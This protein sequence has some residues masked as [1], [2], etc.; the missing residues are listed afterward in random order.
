MEVFVV[1]EIIFELEI[2]VLIGLLV[3]G[4]KYWRLFNLGLNLGSNS[5]FDCGIQFNICSLSILP[6][7]L[8]FGVNTLKNLFLL[9]VKLIS[10]LERVN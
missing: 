6:V 5:S 4:L 3:M 7:L 2:L 10:L 8:K 1:L 9:S